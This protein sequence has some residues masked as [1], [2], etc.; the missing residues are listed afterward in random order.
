M[1][2]GFSRDRRRALGVALAA[3]IGG[4][5]ALGAAGAA[6]AQDPR[7]TTVQ[8]VAR[9]WLQLTDKLD[10][11]ASYRA[12]GARF[13]RSMSLDKWSERLRGERMSLGGMQQRAVLQTSFE[14]SF[15]GVP[16]GEYALVLF[17]AS[18]ALRT[19]VHETVTLERGADGAWHVIG[20]SI[21]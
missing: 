5:L 2:S 7:T 19:D 13:R 4:G 17:R 10:S 9:E 8:R 6:S 12:A 16:D 21:R 11:A 3:F 1:M 18:F 15:P 14:K 20:Y